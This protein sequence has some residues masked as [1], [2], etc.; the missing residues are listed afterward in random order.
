[1]LVEQ[2]GNKKTKRV[3]EHGFGKNSNGPLRTPGGLGS[4]VHTFLARTGEES[5]PSQKNDRRLGIQER[6]GNGARIKQ[7]PRMRIGSRK[8]RKGI[9]RG[10]VGTT[11]RK[12]RDDQKR[13]FNFESEARRN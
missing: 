11:R 2:F 10:G 6:A 13:T 3:G 12:E 5:L 1:M 8:G 7:G 9:E 4:V